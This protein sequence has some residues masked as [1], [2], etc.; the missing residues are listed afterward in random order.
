MSDDTL[1]QCV[2]A[3]LLALHGGIAIWYA[4]ALDGAD[5]KY[6]ALASGAWGLGMVAVAIRV[7]P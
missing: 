2:A 1:W 4:F 5:T 6:S 3:T 7:L